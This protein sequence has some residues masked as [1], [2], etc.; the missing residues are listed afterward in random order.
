MDGVL[1]LGLAGEGPRQDE[2]PHYAERGLVERR[3]VVL[4]H[5]V[6]VDRARLTPD[7]LARCMPDCPDRRIM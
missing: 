2:L 3:K 6:E 4:V 7:Q 5:G 1:G